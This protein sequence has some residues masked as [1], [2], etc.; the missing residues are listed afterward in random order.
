MTGMLAAVIQLCS[1]ADREENLREAEGWMLAAVQRGA[2]LLVL[3][4]NFSF[5]GRTEEEKRRHWEDPVDG[6]SLAFLRAFA[7]RHGV[8]VVGGSIPLRVAGLERVT[9]TCFVVDGQGQVRARYDKIHLFDVDLGGEAPYRESDLVVPGERAVWVEM[10][11][12][13]VGLS[14]CY[15]L[16]FPELYRVLAGAGA[17]VMTVPAAFTQVTGGAH[18]E[19]LLR[20]RAVE[21]FAYVLAAGQGGRHEGGRVTY[22]HSMIVEPWGAIVAQCGEG[23]GIAVAEL[24]MGYVE[25]SRRRIPCLSHRKDFSVI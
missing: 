10:P 16:R 3:P 5:M 22:G 23:P 6:P 25:R 4:E 13:R 11:F 14:I 15:D 19:V 8:W 2:E 18:W 9:N 7:G 12:G 20:A 1:T 21:N 24:E 17:V